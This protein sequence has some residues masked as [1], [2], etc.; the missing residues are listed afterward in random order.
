MKGAQWLQI[1]LFV[2]LIVAGGFDIG[3]GISYKDTSVSAN[4]SLSLGVYL[5]VYGSVAVIAGILIAIA[6][7]DIS[8]NTKRWLHAAG[9]VLMYFLALPWNVVGIVLAL[10]VTEELCPEGEEEVCLTFPYV[11]LIIS[12]I[13]GYLHTLVFYS[14]ELDEDEYSTRGYYSSSRYA[15]M[16][17]KQRTALNEQRSKLS[18][19]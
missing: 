11:M 18:L 15:T 5:I 14:Y 19:R 12:L 2:L 9:G 1:F 6:A 3:V 7:G 17:E 8:Y 4:L 10:H 16:S 13:F